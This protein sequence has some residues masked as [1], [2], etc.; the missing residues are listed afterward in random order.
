MIQYDRPANFTALQAIS[1]AQKLAFSPIA[2]QASVA[3]VRLGIL[4]LVSKAREEGAA[5]EE[6]A[7]RLG[8][9]P[10]G[11]RVLLD[12]GLS[13]GLVWLRGD[14]YVRSVRLLE[15]GGDVTRLAFVQLRET[16][17]ALSAEEARQLAQ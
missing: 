1:E 5:A 7:Q 4:E 14:R 8:L 9:D 3:L 11:V 12:M 16:P 13:I 10:Y 6:V 2:F 17:A 15:P